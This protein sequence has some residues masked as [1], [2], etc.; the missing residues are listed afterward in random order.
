MKPSKSRMVMFVLCLSAVALLALAPSA[1]ADFQGPYEMQNWSSEVTL[2]PLSVAINPATGPSPSAE[3]SY[4]APTPYDFTYREAA[5]SATAT[6]TGTVTF[7]WQYYFFHSWYMVYADLWLYADGPSGTTV[8]H[9]VDFFNAYYTGPKTF[10]GSA[11]IDVTEG[12]E[13]GLRVGGSNYDYSQIL[14]GK[15]TVTNFCFPFLPILIDIK[16]GSYPNSFNPNG[17]GV[18]PIAILGSAD[19]DVADVDVSTLSFEGASVRVKGND[20][21]QCSVQDVSGPGGIPDGYP[22]LVCQFLDDFPEGWLPGD[23][24]ASVTGYLLDGTPIAGSDSISIA[25]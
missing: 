7:D 14:E 2:G 4:D 5:F 17:N 1:S 21:P 24:G 11:S 13:F 19:L 8:Q 6:S 16:P 22:D 9:L 3:F 15:V 20:S 12:Y 10:T 18:I 25:P 23:G